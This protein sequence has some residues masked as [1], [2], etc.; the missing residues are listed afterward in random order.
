MVIDN[1]LFLNVA[2]DTIVPLSLRLEQLFEAISKHLV[3]SFSKYSGLTL[4]KIRFNVLS[5][6]FILINMTI[7]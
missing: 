4:R 2:N 5:F 3:N 1:T 7:R 6:M